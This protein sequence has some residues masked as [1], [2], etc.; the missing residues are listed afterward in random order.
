MNTLS[1]SPILRA[2]DARVTDSALVVALSDGRQVSVPLEWFPRLREATPQQRR[3]WRMVGRGIGLRWPDVDEDILVETLLTPEWSLPFR[4]A[5][6]GGVR[7]SR[8]RRPLPNA[9][10]L[11]PRR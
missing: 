9:R 6:R 3:N 7:S 4:T 11:A 5:R 1:S 10:K 2:V 8:K